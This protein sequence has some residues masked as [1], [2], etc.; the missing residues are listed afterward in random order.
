[1][2]FISLSTCFTTDR[3]SQT[4]PDIRI[5]MCPRS[6]DF[7]EVED[8]RLACGEIWNT[9]TREPSYEF[10]TETKPAK[11]L[12]RSVLYVSISV[13]RK[14]PRTTNIQHDYRNHKLQISESACKYSYSIPELSESKLLIG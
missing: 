5:S 3:F 11:V 4:V 13:Y 2:Y 6:W 1:M 10:Y 7:I 14:T 12:R 8:S 9:T